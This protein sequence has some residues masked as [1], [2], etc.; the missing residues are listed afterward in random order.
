MTLNR[1]SVHL[2]CL[3]A[4]LAAIPAATCGQQ[5]AD[6]AITEAG[7]MHR[8]RF[9]GNPYVR[10]AAFSTDGRVLYILRNDQAVNIWVV[11][12]Y[13]W[14][15][16]LG[17]FTAIL[18]IVCSYAIW[19]I[20]QRRRI[21]GEP[22]C[23]R[24]NYCLRGIA[25][26]RCPECGAPAV[27]PIIGKPTWRRALPFALPLSI[28]VM[29][30]GSLWA[31]GVPRSGSLGTWVNW[32]SYDVSAWAQDK[33]VSLQRWNRLVLR[34]LE[35]DVVT[36]RTLGTLITRPGVVSLGGPFTV[37]PD[38][39]ALLMTVGVGDHLA[40]V[41]TGSGRV[42]RTLASS[43]FSSGVTDYWRQFAGFDAHGTTAFVVM[44]DTP[45]ERTKLLRWNLQTGE[46]SLV[47]ECEADVVSFKNRPASP[48][49]RRF[50]TIPGS[51][52]ARFLEL[53][54]NMAVGVPAKSVE[55]RVRRP[56]APQLNPTTI[57]P[58]PIHFSAPVIYSDG[59]RAN[60]IVPEFGL[61]LATF[62]LES[63]ER[64]RDWRAPAGHFIR[65]GIG[66]APRHDRFIV[67]GSWHPPLKRGL[68]S[69]FAGLFKKRS[70]FVVGDLR[71]KR[72]IARFTCPPEGI[73]VHAPVV[74]PDGR[75]FAAS[76]F[77]RDTKSGGRYQQ[78]LLIFDLRSLPRHGAPSASTPDNAG[79]SP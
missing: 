59:S 19:R 1:T 2:L 13:H 35:I 60:V 47:I 76:G 26:D 61:N 73:Y 34:V 30:Y 42:L 31:C 65:S 46:S 15:E 39:D 52:P 14:P 41:S 79:H 62:D 38:G 72:W 23:R 33:G 32:W 27:Q 40:L 50:Y 48:W 58:P 55:I 22:H 78:E 10:S 20:R 43:D 69:L 37:T 75:F 70:G 11:L 8:L 56:D 57:T 63:G 3:A 44:L 24:C 74:S 77:L 49:P 17:S 12:I 18:M 66:G 7:P 54:S 6:Y 64:L 25:G 68:V 5:N 71:T 21:V 45:Q 4:L 51:D 29:G 9:P 53:P 16:I 67:A 28:A 36:G